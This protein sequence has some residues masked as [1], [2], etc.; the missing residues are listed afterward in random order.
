MHL[1][2]FWSPAQFTMAGCALK[3]D[4]DLI[5]LSLCVV[6][7]GPPGYER[8]ISKAWS[9][10][11]AQTVRITSECLS[12]GA[13]WGRWLRHVSLVLAFGHWGWLLERHDQ[14][15]SG[16]EGQPCDPARHVP[17]HGWGGTVAYLAGSNP[18]GCIRC[19]LWPDDLIAQRETAADRVS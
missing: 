4:E 16:R 12:L 14:E 5:V 7:G 8:R 9:A 6:T 3:A 15:P 1:W 11:H 13:R 18:Q 2:T 17:M 19:R 10:L